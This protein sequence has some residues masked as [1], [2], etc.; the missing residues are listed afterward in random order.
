M[1]NLDVVKN[2]NQAILQKMQDAVKNSDTGAFASAFGD[3]AQAMQE[4]VLKDAREL[5]G[6]NDAAVLA[7]RGVR[8]LTAEER[9]YFQKLG[10]AMKSSA[11]QQA[12]T[13]INV[14][15]PETEI[16]TIFDYLTE[17]HPLLAAID[18]Q[19][20]AAL[21]KIL[22]STSS[23][24]AGWDELT[25]TIDD[26][27]A[28]AFSVIDLTLMKV[29]AYIPVANS[30]LDLGPEWL[31][32]WVRTIL[33]EAIAVAVE[34]A[35]VDGDGNKKPLGMTRALTGAVDGVYP[36]KT[37]VALNAITPAAFGSILNTIS[38][39]PNSKRRAVPELLM[40]VNPADYYTKVFPATTVRRTDGG[41]NNDVFPYPTK[42]IVSAA[43]PANNV[44]IGFAKEYFAGLG[45][46]LGGKIE[47]SD[48]AKFLEDTRVYKIKLY[49]NGRPKDTNAFVL[50]DI[51]NLVPSTLQVE[52]TN[53][54]DFPVA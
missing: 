26:E 28:G 51:T 9:E 32:R 44:V 38:Q 16:D 25:A 45:S 18:F 14:V 19:N 15:M 1:K 39:A 11:P 48:H 23:G 8:Q 49:G 42:V 24:V 37:A 4:A 20:T 40:L 33:A 36:R 46:G 50:C 17:T 41:W 52:V 10:E 2:E 31:E 54:E 5:L 7:Q 3:F 43:V 47:Y 29:S 53:I 22:A 34:G 30:M 6:V 35:I 27:L 13:N 21:Q 12:L